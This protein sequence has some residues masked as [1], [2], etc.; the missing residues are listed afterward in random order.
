MLRQNQRRKAT[1]IL[2]QGTG[3]EELLAAIRAKCRDCCCGSRKA[4]NDCKTYDCHLHKYRNCLAL[5]QTD[6][7]R[8]DE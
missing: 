1:G 8:K 3:A 7:F 2:L 5:V 6:M 4:V